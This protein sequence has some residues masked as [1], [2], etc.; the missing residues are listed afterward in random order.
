M[1]PSCIKTHEIKE[2]EFNRKREGQFLVALEQAML[3]ENHEITIE[4]G[5][6]KIIHICLNKHLITANSK[7]D[8][9]YSLGNLVDIKDSVENCMN[10]QIQ[11]EFVMELC[12]RISEVINTSPEAKAILEYNTY[13]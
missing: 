1:K 6:T 8:Y 4:L 3:T 7:L 5:N 13:A 2:Q 12:P 11:T 9:P 10:D